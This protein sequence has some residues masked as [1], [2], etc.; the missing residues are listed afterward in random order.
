MPNACAIDRQA[1][2]HRATDADEDEVTVLPL[3]P[4]R[5][6]GIDAPGSRVA[7]GV[8]STAPERRQT[9]T[10]CRRGV[11]ALVR[12]LLPPRRDLPCWTT[13]RKRAVLRPLNW[14]W[15]RAAKLR[16]ASRPARR[17]IDD[18]CLPTVVRFQHELAAVGDERGLLRMQI[19]YPDLFEALTVFSQGN[20]ALQAELQARL[21]AAESQAAIAKK[22]ALSVAAVQWFA[23]LF[24]DVAD[25]LQSAS[26][27]VQ[28]A[29]RWHER[30]A[31][32]ALFATWKLLGFAYGPAVVDEL[33]FDVTPQSRP[34][35]P[36]EVATA[37]QADAVA[38]LRRRAVVAMRSLSAS[39]PKAMPL[40]LRSYLRLLDLE[41]R[42]RQRC[43]EHA[44]LCPSF[45]LNCAEFLART[46]VDEQKPWPLR[47]APGLD[48]AT[49]PFGTLPAP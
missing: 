29:I 42:E 17:I 31:T 18:E 39:D 12:S 32:N 24:F 13:L 15:L 44:A 27:V 1:L 11:K 25:R 8:K 21:L 22:T 30:D 14:R 33:V 40:V 16:Y 28:Q 48:L 41:R 34:T 46:A 20:A 43:R 5:S 38:T 37:L 35:T 23:L 7:V 9:T 49:A 10:P 2:L 4:H 45:E 3:W 36:A 19:G 6:P 26:W 47:L